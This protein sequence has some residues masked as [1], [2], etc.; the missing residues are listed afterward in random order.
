MNEPDPSTTASKISR[1]TASA[2]NVTYA[3]GRN[4]SET[5]DRAAKLTAQR[6]HKPYSI[7]QLSRLLRKVYSW[8][9]RQRI[10]GNNPS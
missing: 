1:V 3:T 9:R 8:Q 10:I 6:L 2:G 4:I 7:E 5:V